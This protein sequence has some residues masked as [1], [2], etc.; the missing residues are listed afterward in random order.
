MSISNNNFRGSRKQA[1]KK[2]CDENKTKKERKKKN[3]ERL[4]PRNNNFDGRK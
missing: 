1:T 2:V 3:D 4:S